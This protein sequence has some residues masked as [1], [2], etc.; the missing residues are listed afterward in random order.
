MQMGMMGLGK[1]GANMTRRLMRGGHEMFGLDLDQKAVDALAKGWRQGFDRHGRVH[2]HD[3]EAAHGLDDGSRRRCD[4]E[5]GDRA[6]RAS[7]SRTTRSS[8]AA[9]LITKT[10]CGGRRCWRKRRF[11]TAMRVPAV[12]YGGWIAGTV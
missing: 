1:M 8:T 12:A 7:G 5:D 10:T 2:R 9:I 11:I 6:G 3:G 4:G